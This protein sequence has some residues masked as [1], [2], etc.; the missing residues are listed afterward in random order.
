MTLTVVKNL[1][2]LCP[3]D[4]PKVVTIGTDNQYSTAGVTAKL[5]LNFSLTEESP[6]RDIKLRWSGKTI[7]MVLAN[8]PDGS[9]EQM[10]T[11]TQGQSLADWVDV[12]CENISI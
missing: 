6:G 11:T 1:E 4:N 5:Y 8:V 12:L 7:S 3:I 10:H 9:G 2:I